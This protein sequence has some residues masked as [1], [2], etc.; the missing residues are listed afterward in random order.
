MVTKKILNELQNSPW[1]FK[2]RD[3]L[4]LCLDLLGIKTAAEVGV[5]EGNFSKFILDNTNVEKLYSVDPWEA[6]P[7]LNNPR[8]AYQE[9]ITKLAPYGE[10]SIIVKGYSP[11]VCKNFEAETFD[12]VYLDGLHTYEAVSEDIVGWWPLLN[13]GGILAGHDYNPHEWPGVVRAVNEFAMANKFTVHLT[14]IT[15]YTDEK[16]PSWIIVKE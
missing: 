4:I 15:F 3:S 8:A 11:D 14:G 12:F 10:R 2:D 7:E 13:Q 16:Q 1:T 5:R 9:C 6:N